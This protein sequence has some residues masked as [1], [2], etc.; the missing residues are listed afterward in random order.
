MSGKYD[1]VAFWVMVT[2]AR[3]PSGAVLLSR[4]RRILSQVGIRPIMY[5]LCVLSLILI[6][7]YI[8]IFYLYIAYYIEWTILI[9]CIIYVWTNNVICL[10]PRHGVPF[11]EIAGLFIIYSQVRYLD[12]QMG[13]PN[14]LRVRFRRM[15]GYVIQANWLQ[16]LA[17]SNQWFNNWYL[18]LPALG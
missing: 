5:G 1:Q 18:S 10:A 13:W 16:T 14:E 17:E 9:I 2:P 4:H 3:F 15:T 8:Y 6:Y 7:I 12:N 11:V